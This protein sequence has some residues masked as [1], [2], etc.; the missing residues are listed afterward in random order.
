MYKKIF[1]LDNFDSFTY[2]LVDYFR[3]LG[4][5]VH[6]Y[7][8][9]VDPGIVKEIDPDLIVFSPGPSIPENAGNMMK[10]IRKYHKF[11]PMFGVCL[12]HEAFIEYFGG[13]L[14]FV[15]PMHGK[16]S[17]IHH[18]NRSIFDGVE[19][20]FLAGRYH[21]LCADKVPECFEISATTDDLVM[22]I[23]HKELPIEGVQFH[24]ESVLTMKGG[25]GFRMI[26]NV[27]K[28]NFGINEI[29]KFLLEC[30]E[31]K[32]SIE[33]QVRFL[34]KYSPE[35][36]SAQDLKVF[37]NFIIGKV[38]SNLDM[39]GAID[40]CGTGGSGL[41]R[42]NTSTI[43]AFI[44][45]SLG[46]KVA[47]HGNKAASG[48]FGSFDLLES[49]G[50]DIERED[51][52]KAFEEEN[53]AFIYARKF[54]P[55]M[56]CFAAAR[57][58]IGKPTV[59]NL[60]GPLINPAHPKKQ[61]IG[62]SFKNQMKLI[63]ET[64]KLLGKDNVMVIRGRDGLDEVTL[65]DKTDIVEL[66][67][68]KI[69]E[70]SIEPEDF[71]TEKCEFEKIEGGEEEV[72]VRIAKD[73]LSG[74][75]TSRHADLV[76]VNC[77]LA[78]KLS[79]VCENLKD[80]FAM[81]KNSAGEEKLNSYKG[82]ILQEIAASK[83]I[84]K[85]GNDFYSAIAKPGLSL[86]AEIKKA[87][88]SK[89][90]ILKGEFD[91]IKIAKIYEKAGANAIS[92]LT[93]EKYFGG[94]FEYLKKV[95]EATKLP[96]LCK[97]FIVS[98]Y[99][100]VKAREYGADAILLIA[101]LLDVEKIEKFINIARNF[102]METIVEIHNE[103]ELQK[104]LQTSAKII[105]INNRN[106]KDFSIDLKTTERLVKNIPE[107]RLVVSESGF[108]SA[109]DIESLDKRVNAVLIGSSFMASQDINQKLNEITE[110]IYAK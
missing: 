72:N 36:I 38:S 47:K 54:Y 55:L 82:N 64:A 41:E 84:I 12:G 6:V 53:L 68:G 52:E 22:A 30:L 10:I 43:S 77:A 97:D 59:F 39:P 20:N 85:S 11:Y 76:Y 83:T 46:M 90:L 17:K 107:D 51:L 101:A 35:K 7:R 42:I 91:V 58:Q 19:E 26:E 80:A 103:D 78:L 8:N 37:V 65:T 88:P 21:S 63:A 95:R 5:D 61:I 28:K 94:S 81:A 4:C 48:R 31:N 60:I 98:E 18:D 40:I 29:E 34:E 110:A 99:Q 1:L 109:N 102:G 14:K 45:A 50:I 13:S 62:T 89:G 87:S 96:L 3:Q 74:K 92:V 86:I 16:S 9:T 79:G 25:N 71:G 15:K 108:E 44:L 49:L 69:L 75:C 2:N 33:E 104:V 106:L 70:Y 73:I 56:K 24:P 27:V 57:E 67:D 93:D 100:I 23:R 105:G 32:I 66:S